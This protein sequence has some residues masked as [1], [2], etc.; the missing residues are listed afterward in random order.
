[1][2][3]ALALSI[4][5]VLTACGAARFSLVRPAASAPPIEIR[6]L[7]LS[8]SNVFLVREG[9]AAI[10][11]DSG[12]PGDWD[13]LVSALD[14]EHLAPRDLRLVVL[15]HGHADH[16]GLALRLQHEGVPIALGEGDLGMA[17]RGHDDA[18]RA[19]SPLGDLLRPFVDFPYDAFTPDVIVTGPIGLSRWGIHGARIVPMPGHTPGALV[20]WIGDAEALVGDE[21]LGGLGGA[22]GSGIAGEHFYQ[23]DLHRNHCNVLRLLE[24]GV[25]RFYVGHGGPLDRPSITGWE[26]DWARDAARCEP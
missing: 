14:A 16:A 12:S 19:T 4:A 17:A 8:W 21:M 26:D 2:R 13:A 7:A 1:M 9:D 18:L 15:T 25:Q 11:V 20:V 22:L 3:L 10:L 5:L 24:A 6:Q 23:T